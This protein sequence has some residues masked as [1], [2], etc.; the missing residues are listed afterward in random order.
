VVKRSGLWGGTALQRITISVDDALAEEFDRLSNDRGYQ[1][2]SEAV[3]D[4]MR[5]VVNARRLEQQD[6][7]CV[8]NLSYTY[9]H[10]ERNLATRLMDM[11]HEHHQLIVATA[12]VHL[13]HEHCLETVMLKGL[14]KEVRDFSDELRAERGV[15]HGVLNVIPVDP[16]GHHA[17]PGAHDHDEA[18]HLAP[19][20]G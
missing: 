12:H 8:A 4:L 3:R 10:H 16:T 19:L 17:H 18:A 7:Y 14:V 11:Q 20:P 13:D 2:R 5:D 9:N 15:R 1:G 6:G